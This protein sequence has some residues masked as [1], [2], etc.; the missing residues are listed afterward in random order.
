MLQIYQSYKEQYKAHLRLAFPVMLTQVGQ[1][2]TQLV[3]TIMV[4]QYGG[5]N[6]VPLAAVSLG[7]SFFFL[8]FIASIGVALGATPLIGKS[9]AEGNHRHTASLFQNGMIFFTLLGLVVGVAQYAAIP[10]MERMQGFLSRFS[11][12]Q[13]NQAAVIEAAIPYYKMLVYSMPFI[14]LFF[15]FKQFLEGVGNTKVE[16]VVTILSNLSNVLFNYLFI[17][18]HMGCPELGIVGAGLGTLLARIVSPVLMILYFTFN[19]TYRSYFEGFSLRTLRISIIKKL[20]KIGLPIS[21]QMFLE[22]SLFALSGIVMLSFGDTASAAGQIAGNVGNCAFMIFLSLGAATTIRISHAYG[23]KDINELKRSAKASYHLVIAWGLISSVLYIAFSNVIPQL[24]SKNEE[25][26]AISSNLL[27]FTALYQFSDGIQNASICILRG[28]Q[29][30]KII[31][32]IAFLSYWVCFMPL[33]YYFG[34]TLEMGPAGLYLGIAFGLSLA[35]LL[36]IL[37]IRKRMR[38]LHQSSPYHT[39]N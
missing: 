9:F 22:A 18:G 29:D 30:V 15:S 19:A 26:I 13:L 7:S 6:P 5:E 16:T 38:I 24:F 8:L 32:P 10:L 31:M 39:E 28:I 17:Y 35:A 2:L 1:V 14:M 27:L 34:F 12:P 25:V 21:F 23:R 4:G 20:L 3:D 33:A 11:D 37:R 36:L